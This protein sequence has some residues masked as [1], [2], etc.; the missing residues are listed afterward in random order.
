MTATDAGQSLKRTPLYE[1]HVRL[2][3][4][5]VPFAGYEMPLLRFSAARNGRGP[6][7]AS[8]ISWAK[9]RSPRSKSISSA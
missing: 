5:T 2:G 4:R 3:A 8:P 1:L 9:H 7:S 6:I